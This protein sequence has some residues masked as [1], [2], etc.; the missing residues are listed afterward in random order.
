VCSA[1]LSA[2]LSVAVANDAKASGL[3]DAEV[4]DY[5]SAVA[6]Q[7][8]RDFEPAWNIRARLRFIPTGHRV[9][10]GWAIID[11]RGTSDEPGALG[12]HDL[13]PEGLPVGYVFAKDDAKYGAN[14]GITFSHEVL[15]LLLDPR[16]ADVVYHQGPHGDEFHAQEA[17]D[18][19][20]ADELGYAVT[21]TGGKQIMVSDF[22]MP[23]YF[24]DTA[25]TRHSARFD[26]M[27]HLGA[28]FSLAPGGYQSLYV[29]GKGWT[30][31]FARRP[32]GRERSPEE[33]AAAK[34]PLSRMARR[35]A[36]SAAGA[37]HPEI[38]VLAQRTR[39]L[40]G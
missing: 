17:C 22:V 28:P 38:E 13:T 33:L 23:D 2:V 40:I 25:A 3:K 31:R 5:V 21:L 20:E 4:A 36:K 26:F 32:D 39:Q 6:T 34:G 18:A 29:P 9:P 19:C 11:V 7:V 24:D 16:I 15:E 12:Y 10:P 1:T 14:P 37:E 30:Q 8:R 27:G 35:V